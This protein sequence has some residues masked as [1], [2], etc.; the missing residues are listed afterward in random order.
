[1]K[2]KAVQ[3]D[4]NSEPGDLSRLLKDFLNLHTGGGLLPDPVGKDAAKGELE[5]LEWTVV[6]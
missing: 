5:P 2:D 4:W 3:T 6:V 1:M